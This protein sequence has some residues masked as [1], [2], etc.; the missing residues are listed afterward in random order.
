MFIGR[1]FDTNGDGNNDVFIGQKLSKEQS[2]AAGCGALIG[3]A[4]AAIAIPIAIAA[5]NANMGIWE[6]VS[7]NF[8][9]GVVGWL[10]GF[11][12]LV[13]CLSAFMQ[14]PTAVMTSLLLIGAWFG[15]SYVGSLLGVSI[16]LLLPIVVG[17]IGVGVVVLA[18]ISQGKSS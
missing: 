7:K 17:I 1:G 3:L 18:V 6:W 10:V 5:S 9:W 15:L 14:P 12:V 13:A 11:F 2:S 8:A 16:W 4:M